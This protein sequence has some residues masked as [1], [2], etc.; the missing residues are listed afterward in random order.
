MET[1]NTAAHDHCH[2]GGSPVSYF[3]IGVRSIVQLVVLVNDRDHF[4][5]VPF[6]RGTWTDELLRYLGAMFAAVFQATLAVGVLSPNLR[7]A[8]TRRQRR[9]GCLSGFS[10]FFIDMMAWEYMVYAIEKIL[11]RTVSCSQNRLFTNRA[12]IYRMI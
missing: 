8:D 7:P 2:L 6:E 3:L 1:D 10:L 4:L 11:F 5:F 12:S 9:T